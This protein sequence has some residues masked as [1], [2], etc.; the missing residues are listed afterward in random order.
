MPRHPS[1][2]KHVITD[3]SLFSGAT[4]IPNNQDYYSSG[5]KYYYH[6]DSDHSSHHDE[7][8]EEVA[9]KILK[10]P[11][12]AAIYNTKQFLLIQHQQN[13][14]NDSNPQSTS[15]S[16]FTPSS[17][18]ITSESS[19]EEPQPKIFYKTDHQSSLESTTT[20]ESLMELPEPLLIKKT[21]HRQ[22]SF[23][24][25]DKTCSEDGVVRKNL[26]ST[27]QL[28]HYKKSPKFLRAS[29]KREESKVIIKTEEP[30]E[31]VAPS[32]SKMNPLACLKAKLC[33]AH[34]HTK[35]NYF[36][37]SSSESSKESTLDSYRKL[38]H[39]LRIKICKSPGKS[40]KKAVQPKSI[41]LDTKKPNILETDSSNEYESETGIP[42]SPTLF[43]SGV[44]I[45][46]TPESKSNG[47]QSRSSSLTVPTVISLAGGVTSTSNSSLNN[48]LPPP[49]SPE[50]IYT[51]SL[52]MSRTPQTSYTNLLS[53]SNTQ[54]NSPVTLSPSKLT[55]MNKENFNPTNS[56]SIRMN[57]IGTKS[58]NFSESTTNTPRVR[59][60]SSG[61]MPKDLSNIIIS[62]G[63]N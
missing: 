37:K 55:S 28:H 51:P 58:F 9:K 50:Y 35:T 14:S 30:S 5:S 24:E 42:K 60:N 47:K 8:C 1:N 27:F 61:V 59:S 43:I 62:P 15:R 32:T 16:V 44:S 56:T 23:D 21:I 19:L 26:D 11:S 46:R 40:H 7:K 52:A 25:E 17:G 53:A 41:D 13:D 10:L 3:S 45:S 12:S 54:K 18:G 33:S 31:E 29:I 57:D 4:V 20:S 22:N 34:F 36:S 38:S 39:N 49:G 63:K 2:N 48:I 6:F